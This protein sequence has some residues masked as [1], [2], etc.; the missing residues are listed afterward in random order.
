MEI[1]L[2]EPLPAIA[3]FDQLSVV[4]HPAATAPAKTDE[5]DLQSARG[6]AHGGKFFGF[7]HNSV[8]DLQ[9]ATANFSNLFL[10]F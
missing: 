8:S 1:A 9:N 7:L 6:R 5:E 2:G 3:W 4:A 10:A